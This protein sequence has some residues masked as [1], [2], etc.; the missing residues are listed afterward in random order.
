MALLACVLLAGAPAPAFAEASYKSESLSQYESQLAAGQVASV[1]IDK[2]THELRATLKN[3]EHVV[4]KYPAKHESKFTE[5]LKAKGVAVTIL[6]Q[7]QA[8]AEGRKKAVH[9]KIRY[10]AGGVLI[11]V[12]VIVGAVLILRRRRRTVLRD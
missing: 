7:A 12:I 11:A 3:G 5:E 8:R 4:A 10:I 2:R 1:T 9:H 6:T